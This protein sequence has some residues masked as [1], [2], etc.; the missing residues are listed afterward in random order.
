MARHVNTFCFQNTRKTKLECWSKYK[1]L[2][3]ITLKKFRLIGKQLPLQ[4]ALSSTPTSSANGDLH[5]DKYHLVGID[6]R[7]KLE[8]ISKIMFFYV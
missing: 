6:L 8:A 5:T 3:Q 7:G 4:K 2:F 1:C